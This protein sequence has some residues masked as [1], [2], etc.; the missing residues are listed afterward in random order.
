MG[1]KKIARIQPG[2][3]HALLERFL[4]WETSHDMRIGYIVN[5]SADYDRAT[6]EYLK[7]LSERFPR[8]Y[9]PLRRISLGGLRKRT[10]EELRLWLHERQQFGCISAHGS[11]AG[12]GEVH[13]YW[14][15]QRGNYD[16]IVRTLRIAGEIGMAIL[17][18]LFVVKSTLSTL[19]ELND[20]LDTLPDHQNNCRYAVPYFYAG[21]GSRLEEERIDER[22]RDELPSWLHR[23][24]REA[25]SAEG[26][27]RSEREWIEVIRNDP[28]QRKNGLILNV[29]EDN[30]ERLEQQTCDEIIGDLETR[31]RTAYAAIPGLSELC[32]R[33]G[34]RNGTMIYGLERCLEMKWLDRHLQEHPTEFERQLTHLQLGN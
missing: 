9:E 6:L 10:D 19:Q 7:D 30:I 5:Y 33:Y 17:A 34:D 32:E 27:C 31:T 21:W 4:E 8:D 23:L 15:G 28:A 12:H 25:R 29:T 3:L 2:R 11:F 24:L 13:D 1:K 20:T 22:T 14:N 16:L 18:R 26:E